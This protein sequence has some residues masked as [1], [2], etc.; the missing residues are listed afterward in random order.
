MNKAETRP[1]ARAALL[2]SAR[3]S[4]E[5]TPI[6][7]RETN[8]YIAAVPSVLA[9]PRNQNEKTDDAHKG[10][11][12]PPYDE[13]KSEKGKGPGQGARTDQLSGQD[14]AEPA[15]ILPARSIQVSSPFTKGANYT[16]N[17]RGYIARSLASISLLSSFVCHLLRP[18]L[19]LQ[20]CKL[21]R[22]CLWFLDDIFSWGMEHRIN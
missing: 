1:I 5:G 19:V 20:V 4:K 12:R 7:A 2:G 9:R 18:T 13:G 6:S 10:L 3:L 17:A 21:I 16:S 8:T 15:F 14:R 11:F 22:L